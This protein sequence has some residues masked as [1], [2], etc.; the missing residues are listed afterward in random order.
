MFSASD[1]SDFE[2]WRKTASILRT[3]DGL[4]E[5]FHG[6]RGDGDIIPLIP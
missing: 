1:G 3:G 2:N 6:G 4:R 5:P